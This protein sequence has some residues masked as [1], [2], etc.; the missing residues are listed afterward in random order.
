MPSLFGGD[1]SC[2][3][4]CCCCC[5]CWAVRLFVAKRYELALLSLMN[6]ISAPLKVGEARRGEALKGL[7]CLAG[8]V[9][10]IG[11]K[12][13]QQQQE[14][15]TPT[16]TNV[17]RVF[18]KRKEKTTSESSQSVTGRKHRFLPFVHT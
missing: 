7:G 17:R 8:Q 3:C 2:C 15:Q 11:M 4:C 6:R 13:Q 14:Q 5:C 12:Q 9:A 16:R 18:L 1:G 10:V